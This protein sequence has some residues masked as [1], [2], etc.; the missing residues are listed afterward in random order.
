M[1]GQRRRVPRWAIG[2]LALAVVA[3]AA[4]GLAQALGGSPATRSPQ[5]TPPPAP[6][7][8]SVDGQATGQPVEGILCGSATGS[9]MHLHAH[10][11]I[12]VNGA[13]RGVPL[14]IG[15]PG[16]TTVQTVSGPRAEAAGCIYWLRTETPDGVIHIDSPTQRQFTLGQLFAIWRQPLTT[17]QVGPVAGPVIAYVDGQRFGGDPGDITLGSHTLVQLDVGA[18]VPPQSFSFPA[19]L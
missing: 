9:A 16:A 18:D 6:A 19:G 10:L 13:A 1:V 2:A 15:M 12:Y 5:A 14:G 17:T 8:A 11:G 4:F 3:V 7:L